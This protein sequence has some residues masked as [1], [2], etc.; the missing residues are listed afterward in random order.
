[1]EIIHL[2]W[3]NRQHTTVADTLTTVQHIADVVEYAGGD[4]GIPPARDLE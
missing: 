3:R 1:V 4:L 2:D